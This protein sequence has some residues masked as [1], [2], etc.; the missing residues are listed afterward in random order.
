M[1][2]R[3]Q[4]LGILRIDVINCIMNGEIIEDYPTD[5]PHPSCLIFGHDT[6]NN[7]GVMLWLDMMAIM[8]LL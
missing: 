3:I 5:Y 8:C 2:N 7:R 1:A 6:L 4:Q